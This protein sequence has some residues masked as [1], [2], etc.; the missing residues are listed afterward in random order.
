MDDIRLEKCLEAIYEQASA[1]LPPECR[2]DCPMLRAIGDL[3]VGVK[4]ENT[5]R[6]SIE[7]GILRGGEWKCPG[8]R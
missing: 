7:L 6:I 4:S 5:E 8:L 1:S 3:L 2:R